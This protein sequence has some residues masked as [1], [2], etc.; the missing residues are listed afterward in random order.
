MRVFQV[1][2]KNNNN[3]ISI[4]RRQHNN[5]PKSMDDTPSSTISST[6]AASAKMYG[7]NM[8]QNQTTIHFEIMPD[9]C[10]KTKSSFWFLDLWF[11]FIIL[12]DAQTSMNGI[13][14]HMNFD[15]CFQC[16]EC[17]NFSIWWAMSMQS[18]CLNSLTRALHGYRQQFKQRANIY[19]PLRFVTG[20]SILIGYR[21]LTPSFAVYM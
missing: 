20:W 6:H 19:R 13:W 17:F 8:S 2:M 21:I 4:N 9:C 1:P 5:S 16:F 15:T 14:I 12:M 10:S 18:A 11:L 7:L 3:N